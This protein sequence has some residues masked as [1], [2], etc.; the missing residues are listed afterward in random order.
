MAYSADDYKHQAQKLSPK[1]A[2]WP[3]DE[4][5]SLLNKLLGALSIESERIDNRAED[6]LKEV[7]PRQTSELLADFERL[8]GL[9]EGCYPV[10][11]STIERRNAVI[12]KL[13][14]RGGQSRQYF[15]DVAA[16]LGIPITIEEF[17]PLKAGFRAGDRCYSQEW[18]WVWRVHAPSVTIY[19]FRAGQSK[20]GDP[21]ATWGNKMLECIIKRLKPAHTKVLFAY[22]G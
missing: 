13:L 9:P 20:A 3:I 17:E 12:A 19:K 7:D 21:L 4:P 22:D 18:R 2:A 5:E 14:A 16:S 15:I 10:P 6:L 8:C 1:G 11:E